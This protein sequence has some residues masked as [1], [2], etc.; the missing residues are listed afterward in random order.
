MGL[1]WTSHSISAMELSEILE[2]LVGFPWLRPIYSPQ[3][4]QKNSVNPCTLLLPAGQEAQGN[5]Y[6]VPTKGLR[7]KVWL[8]GKPK[9]IR[10]SK[11]SC[12]VEVS[13]RIYSA[14]ISKT[15]F[16]WAIYLVNCNKKKVWCYWKHSSLIN[17]W[18][19][20][21]FYWSF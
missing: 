20:T 2:F 15:M 11:D 1:G 18:I 16:V 21:N 17:I 13:F 12:L 10:T 9:Y 14:T 8:R 4:Q 6:V 5:N 19:T 3:P 7:M